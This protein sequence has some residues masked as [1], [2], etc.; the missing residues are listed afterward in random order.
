[1]KFDGAMLAA[2][3]CSIFPDILL[4]F[5][6]SKDLCTSSTVHRLLCSSSTG[7]RSSK[8]AKFNGEI[9]CLSEKKSSRNGH[10]ENRTLKKKTELKK[11][12]Q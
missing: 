8:S 12:T 6:V 10:S 11:W 7:C 5:D 4:A 2:V 9:E 1:M 3:A